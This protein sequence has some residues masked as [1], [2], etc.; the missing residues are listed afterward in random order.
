LRH[1]R[2]SVADPTRISGACALSTAQQVLAA[3]DAHLGRLD[4]AR[5]I[6]A[7]LQAFNSAVILDASLLRGPEGREF[8][9]SG[10][11]LAMAAAICG[12]VRCL[13]A[14]PTALDAPAHPIFSRR[15]AKISPKRRCNR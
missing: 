6:V 8:R 5:Q 11:R 14:E 4:K 13:A 7:R 1:C 12:G 3:W 2:D 10:L 15:T 9:L